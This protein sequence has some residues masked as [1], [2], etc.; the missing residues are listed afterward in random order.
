VDIFVARQAIFDREQH[1]FGYELLF[2]SSLNNVFDGTDGTRATSQVITTSFFSLGVEKILGGKRAFIN[3][4]RDLLVGE[5]ASILPR[6]IAMVEILE[7]VPPDSQVMAA[8]KN[9]KER[10][11][12]LVLDDFVCEK[13][14]EPLA[15][16]AD[17]I[18]VDFLATPEPERLRLVRHYSARGTKM[19][20]EKVETYEQFKQAHEMG[21]HY[22]QGYFFAHP[23]VISGRGIPA[24][25]FHYLQILSEISRP[26][27]D[28]QRLEGIIKQEVSLSYKLLRYINSA[29]FGW[30]GQIESIKQALVLLGESE[31]RK[32]LSL[33]A[34]PSLTQDKPEELVVTAAVRARFC[35]SLAPWIG[36][37]H[38]KTDLFFLG[39]F[40]LLDAIMD[41]PLETVLTE[42]R[43]ADDVREALLGGARKNSR[44]ARVHALVR[45][46]EMAGWEAVTSITGQL[47]LPPG[48]TAGLYLDAVSWADRIFRA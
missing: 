42:I 25:K 15:E 35:E 10:G 26:E 2:R 9:L 44:L 48:T 34:L 28:Y 14:F 23:V 19:L 29:A 1:V 24:F 3:F 16:L 41:R 12:S 36:L 18:K 47:G 4:N 20:A 40:S 6:E 38:R 17:I 21:F 30:R 5:C 11:Y 46:H 33:V 43:L 13:R 37:G 27:L 8:C 32:W 7:S 45:A 22:F 31:I 39:M